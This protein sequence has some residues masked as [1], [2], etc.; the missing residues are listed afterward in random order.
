MNSWT[1]AQ[2]SSQHLWDVVNIK[3]QHPH[4]PDGKTKETV[5]SWGPG[6]LL[7]HTCTSKTRKGLRV[8]P[9]LRPTG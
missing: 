1:L 8:H 9:S 4:F 5:L 7:I 3:N 2:P 6:V